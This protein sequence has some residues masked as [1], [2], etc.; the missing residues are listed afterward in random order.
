MISKRQ[1]I[2]KDYGNKLSK[3]QF[4]HFCNY[5]EALSVC[6]KPTINRFAN[7]YSTDRSSMNR[8]LTESPWKINDLKPIF[9]NQVVN[10]ISDNSFL[11]LDDTI[12]HRPYAKK[13]EKANYHYDHTNN[14]QSMGYC[15]LTS[16]ICSNNMN[17]PYDM[18]PYYRNV[19][20][21][22]DTFK[23]KNTLASEIIESTKESSKITTVIFDSWFSND[24]VI[25]ACKGANKNFIT[26]I[27]SNRN[28]TLS[29]QK[30]SVKAHAKHIT[31]WRILD[32]NK[33]KFRF[34]ATS[35]FISKIGSVHLIFSQMYLKK[36]K[37]WSQTNYIISNQLDVDSKQII[38]DYLAR[39][40][41]E[42]FHREAKQ[43]T[44]LEG[45]FLRNN[46][47]IEKYLFLVML[48]YTFLLLKRLNCENKTIGKSCEDEK[49]RVLGR[50]FD[51]ITQNPSLR[52][53][54]LRGLAIAK[55]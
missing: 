19:D 13:V 10:T 17:I 28:I 3:P 45:Y 25:G 29:N 26:Q 35:A 48:S 4:K 54:V 49:V 42:C 9:K 53:E 52:E 32:V 15:I 12:S 5:V 34:F 20:C 30:R 43:N 11:L 44:G 23:T 38:E 41:I 8:F 18:V 27:K 33:D 31:Q 50:A 39:W 7:L 21:E 16:T 46:R 2:L 55:V 22:N 40:G 51:R 47:G 1:G 24:Q 37:K 6:E 14:K 36:T